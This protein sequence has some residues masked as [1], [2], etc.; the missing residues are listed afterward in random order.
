M[1]YRI[2]AELT[3]WFLIMVVILTIVIVE[4]FSG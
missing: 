2:S 4:A 3:F 1:A